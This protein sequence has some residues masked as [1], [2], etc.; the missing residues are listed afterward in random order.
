MAF[1]IDDT[2]TLLGVIERSYKPTTTLVDTFFPQVQTFVTEYVDIE[3]R[4][5]GR[6]MAPFVVPG[7]KGVNVARTGSTLR[8]YKAPLMKPKRTIELNDVMRRGFGEDIYSQRTPAQRAQEMRAKDMSELIDDCAR[9]QEWMAAQLLINGEY[10]IKGYADD[11]ATQRIDTVAFDFTNKT[12]LSGDDAWSNA[13]ASIL[14]VLGDVSQKIRREANAV[15][16]V[17]ICSLNVVKYLMKNE[18]LYKYL[19]VPN[20]ENLAFIN[21]QPRLQRPD[22]LRVGL[23]QALNLEIYAYDGVYEDDETG[24]IAQYIPDDHMIIGIPGRGKR[25]FGAVTQMEDN[26]QLQTYASEYVPKVTYDLE[27][28]TSSL[29]ISSRCVLCPEFLDEWAVIKCADDSESTDDTGDQG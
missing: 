23:L 12:T 25:L 18:E 5:G 2:R 21:L 16:T 11:G 4:K 24:E 13:S 17:A 10:E 22:L 9:R 28:D 3:Y 8:S 19:L 15:P 29:A 20:R 6:K 7:S 14:D 27:S 1:N 26:H